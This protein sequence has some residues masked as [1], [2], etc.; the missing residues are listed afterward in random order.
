MITN[1]SEM[2]TQYSQHVRQGVPEGTAR[3]ACRTRF[4]YCGNRTDPHHLP[5]CPT[6]SECLTFCNAHKC[7]D[8]CR[9]SIAIAEHSADWTD[10][11]PQLSDWDVIGSLHQG[12]VENDTNTT[13]AEAAEAGRIEEAADKILNMSLG[14]LALECRPLGPADVHSDLATEDEL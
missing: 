4:Q 8:Q 6:W 10:E 11:D 2:E 12:S 14:N 7:E 9:V 3:L 13:A 1:R 5:T